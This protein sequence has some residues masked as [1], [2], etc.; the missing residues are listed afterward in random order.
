MGIIE[1]NEAL[2]PDAKKDGLLHNTKETPA[3]SLQQG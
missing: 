3:V 1:K 2:T